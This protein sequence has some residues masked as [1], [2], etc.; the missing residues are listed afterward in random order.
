[1][2]SLRRIGRTIIATGGV[3]T[4]GLERLKNGDILASYR[5][6]RPDVENEGG[7]SNWVGEV[8]RSTD[9]GRTWSDR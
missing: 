1:M 5:R 4:P 9:G 6:F 7:F 8:L 3:S 2:A